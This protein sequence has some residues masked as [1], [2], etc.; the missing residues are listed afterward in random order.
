MV[1]D[2]PAR[3]RFELEAEGE[4]AIAEYRREPGRVTFL[5]TEVPGTLRG[6]GLG[7]TLARGA[8]ALVRQS[9]DQVVARC[10]FIADFIDKNPE[11]QALLAP[12]SAGE[13]P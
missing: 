6:R 7:S 3:Q 13:R 12:P 1:K 8:L 10:S 4:L 9:G 11:F 5:H 2:N